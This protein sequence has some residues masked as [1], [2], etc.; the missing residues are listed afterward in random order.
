[1]LRVQSFRKCP[2][3]F[4]VNDPGTGAGCEIQ[5]GH[6]D[7]ALQVARGPGGALQTGQRT[8]ILDHPRATSGKGDPAVLGRF[9]EIQFGIR[10][11]EWGANCRQ[12]VEQAPFEL[13]RLDLVLL[14]RKLVDHRYTNLGSPD[15]V[16]QLRGQ[17]PLDLL[18]AQLRMPSSRGLDLE[19]VPRSA[20]STR[21]GF[22]V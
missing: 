7:Q 3:A 2:I 16:A 15:P 18:A 12:L 8:D 20:K 4:I 19:S 13:P 9:R 1:M 5:V 22:T 10:L 14:A 6:V 21:R 17:I 11:A